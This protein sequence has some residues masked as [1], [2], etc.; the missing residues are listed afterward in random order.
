MTNPHMIEGAL[1]EKSKILVPDPTNERLEKIYGI[2]KTIADDPVHD[3]AIL[4]VCE[5]NMF[6]LSS[7]L[8][9]VPG[10]P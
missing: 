6:S 9:D 7:K 8:A 4:E 1:W 5:R 10:L 3:L 2:S